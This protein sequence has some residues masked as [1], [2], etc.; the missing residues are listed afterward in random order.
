MVKSKGIGDYNLQVERL[1]E[2]IGREIGRGNAI[3][4]QYIASSV[5]YY[6]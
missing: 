1:T 5:R 2:A 6:H 4:C 3:C